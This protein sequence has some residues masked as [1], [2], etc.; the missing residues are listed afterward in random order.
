MYK[1]FARM[2]LSTVPNAP[3]AIRHWWLRNPKQ[4]P[5]FLSFFGCLD[6]TKRKSMGNFNYLTTFT[7]LKLVEIFSPRR[8]LVFAS[9][10]WWSWMRPW[11]RPFEKPG[12]RFPGAIFGRE[13][14][15]IPKKFNKNSRVGWNIL[16]WGIYLYIYVYIWTQVMC[17]QSHSSGSYVCI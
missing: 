15:G 16:L 2:S 17:F 4:Q 5:P 6:E 8:C 3:L 9:K 7:S 13:N 14:V 12:S 1:I 11:R 10:S